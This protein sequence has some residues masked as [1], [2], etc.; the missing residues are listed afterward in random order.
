MLIIAGLFIYLIQRFLQY[1]QVFNEIDIIKE[2]VIVD[3]LYAK[4]V[5]NTSLNQKCANIFANLQVPP[6]LSEVDYSLYDRKTWLKNAIKR[7]KF[8]LSE[9][10]I[11]FDDTHKN[12]VKNQYNKL[13]SDLSLYENQ[14]LKSF[15]QMRLSTQ[16]KDYIIDRKIKKLYPWLK[17]LPSSFNSKGIVIPVL[18]EKITTVRDALIVKLIS[19]LRIQK[20]KLPIEI[21]YFGDDI[22]DQKA[23]EHAAHG[24]IIQ[25]PDSYHD[26]TDSPFLTSD[27]PDQDIK[28]V[29]I[30]S[31]ID[32]EFHHRLN[33]NFMYSLSLIFNSFEEVILLT[34]QTIP[35]TNLEILFN[36]KEYIESGTYFFK[37][38][39]KLSTKPRKFKS[40]FHEVNLLILNLFPNKLDI[41]HFSLFNQASGPIDR[42]FNQS[43]SEL[44]DPSMMVLNK[45]KTMNGL[46]I[47]T[48]LQF[49]LILNG[50]FRD[51][52]TYL[53]PDFIWL[54][55]IIS[56][57]NRI[58][59]NRDFA[60][61]VGMSTPIKCLDPKIVQVSQ[62]VCSS[63]WGQI[64]SDS[65]LTLLYVTTHQLENAKW[66]DDSFPYALERK[67]SYKDIATVDNIF[68][69]DSE[70]KT[71]IDSLN[72]TLYD[73][74]LKINPLYID[75]V[76]KP[77]T[78]QA[79]VVVQGATEPKQ[80][81]ILQD[82]FVNNDAN[83]FYCVYNIVG[84]LA[85]G[86]S[87]K[88]IALND[89]AVKKFNFIT[90]Y[91]L[92]D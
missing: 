38:P 51:F 5:K 41:E 53:N 11:K 57:T 10:S 88:V 66:F 39:T 1:E 7:F 61:A 87:G 25:A 18:P 84:N 33:F 92:Q 68:D 42:V 60:T 21:V 65:A 9:K 76:I 46:L 70:S 45:A 78:L 17:N 48:N 24:E 72:T 28:F 30:T 67:Y 31:H 64:Y 75:S 91:W 79:P 63:S 23:V 85:E 6:L 4:V 58:T 37:N 81:W 15:N 14:L 83:P 35:L 27:Y 74:T 86:K 90:E 80:A 44:V 82:N 2:R 19:S 26:Y 3:P 73:S 55:Q 16:C 47:A 77:P 13:T 8:G 40:G 50:R 71:T 29:N 52:Q 34:H 59:F 12:F 20:N 32:Q 43:F 54:G 69:S 62:E 36:D 56:G 22:C 89:K 49:L